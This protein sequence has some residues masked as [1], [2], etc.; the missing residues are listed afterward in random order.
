M[1]LNN[2]VLFEVI[3][4]SED[5]SCYDLIWSPWNSQSKSVQ[6]SQAMTSRRGC[7]KIDRMEPLKSRLWEETGRYM[8]DD[9]FV[10]SS[11]EKL[12]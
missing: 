11:Y 5:I 7:S 9:P 6:I 1:G 12:N 8:D 2:L 4:I 3:W 10:A